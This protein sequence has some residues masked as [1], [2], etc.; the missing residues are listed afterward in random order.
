MAGL[1][2]LWQTLASNPASTTVAVKLPPLLAST[3]ASPCDRLVRTSGR[4]QSAE[5]LVTAFFCVSSEHD[6]CFLQRCVTYV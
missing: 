6:E 3:F 4:K 1:V 2:A 5:L